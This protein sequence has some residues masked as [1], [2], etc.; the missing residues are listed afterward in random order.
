VQSKE[1]TFSYLLSNAPAPTIASASLKVIGFPIRSCAEGQNPHP[2]ANLRCEFPARFG[3]A[4]D[5]FA[6]VKQELAV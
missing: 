2:H 4:M 6:V 1:P 5:A 3:K